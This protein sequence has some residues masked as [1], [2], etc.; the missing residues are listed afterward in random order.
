MLKDLQSEKDSR[1]ISISRIGICD[2]KLPI[3]L[4]IG[5]KLY[6]SICNITST[7]A[8]DETLRGAHL[9]RIIEVLNDSLYDRIITLEEFK[10]IVRETKLRSNTIGAEINFDFDIIL[11][12]F[13]PVSGKQSFTTANL[14]INNKDMN[15]EEDNSITISL[16]GTTLCPCSKE[17]SEYGAHN[18]KCKAMVTLHGDYEN[19]PFNQIVEAMS[20]QFSSNVYSTVKRKDEKYITEQAYENPKFSEDLIRDLLLSISKLYDGQ[21]DAELVNYESIH[22]HNVYAKGSIDHRPKVKGKDYV[23]D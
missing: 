9:S 4:M 12:S 20:A 17:I 1:H 23:Q 8:L 2:Y 18:Q 14:K 7:V 16:L 22:E 11:R 19:I 6:N 3:A 5:D 15:G 13:A 10:K 21:I